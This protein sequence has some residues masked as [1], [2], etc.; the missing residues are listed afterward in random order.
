MVRFRKDVRLVPR[1]FGGA[2][3]IDLA[4]DCY[5]IP[6]DLVPFAATLA[7]GQ[8]AGSRSDQSCAVPTEFL[9]ELAA[10]SLL[11]QPASIR[12]RLLTWL[13]QLRAAFI[14]VCLSV[15]LALSRSPQKL[16]GRLMGVAYLS[17]KCCPWPVT[18]EAWTGFFHRRSASPRRCLAGLSVDRAGEL[19]RDAAARHFLAVRCKERSLTLFA[20]CR[21]SGHAA[22]VHVGCCPT[23]FQLH[24]WLESADGIVGD[25]ASLCADFNTIATWS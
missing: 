8:G 21:L 23:V 2:F 9:E 5:S 25:D 12:F 15:V 20:L 7:A 1:E 10:L 16:A 18:A 3:L 17:L 22:Q 19:V 14:V 13:N 24:C 4:G 6:E 11:E